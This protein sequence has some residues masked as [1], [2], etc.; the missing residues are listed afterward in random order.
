MINSSIIDEIQWWLSVP[1]DEIKCNIKLPSTDMVIST[2]AILWLGAICEKDNCYHRVK[3][4][5]TPKG[6]HINILELIAVQK[7]L[8]RLCTNLKDVHVH[9]IKSDTS[10]AVS[11]IAKMEGT[12]GTSTI[13]DESDN[14]TAVSYIAKMGETIGTSTIYDESDNST[15]VSYISKM[16]GTIGT[17]TI[18]DESDNSTAV[19]YVRNYRYIHYL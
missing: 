8:Q 2:E 12:I 17:S 7:V 14:S 16:G 4:P 5:E 13:Y 18:Y 10:M 9:V 11:Y 3:W 15:A 1:R 6:I 19:S